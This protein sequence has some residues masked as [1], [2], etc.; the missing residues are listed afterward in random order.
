MFCEHPAFLDIKRC[1]CCCFCIQQFIVLTIRTVSNK[2]KEHN[3]E[4]S[5]KVRV[6]VPENSSN[7]T[8]ED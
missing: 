1:C 7:D 3:I 4:F 6:K 5:L 8:M 2:V